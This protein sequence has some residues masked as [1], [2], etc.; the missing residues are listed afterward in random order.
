[1]LLQAYFV[2]TSVYGWYAW[3]HGGVAHDAVLEISHLGASAGVAWSV[4]AVA[5]SIGLGWFMR[6]YTRAALPYWDAVI[7]VLSLIAQYWLAVKVFETW[8]LWI[9]VDAIAVGVYLARRLRMTAALYAV[10]LCLAVKG[11]LG[12][13]R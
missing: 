1:V 9:A 5:G 3:T 7:T 4:V 12:W 10:L 8:M 6:R 11:L 2:V 13:M